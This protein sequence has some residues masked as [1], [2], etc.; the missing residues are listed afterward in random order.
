MKAGGLGLA[1]LGTAGL[2]TAQGMHHDNKKMADLFD[3]P[4]KNGEY[5]LPKLPYDYDA[6]EPVIDAQTTRLHHDIHF[7]GY[8][9][10][11]NGALKALKEARE[12]GD[13]SMVQ[14]HEG[15]LAFHG[16]GY[17][18]HL[19]FFA[20]LTAPGSSSPSSWMKNTLAEHFGSM[21]RFKAHFAAASKTVEGSGW[22]ILG[23]Q[24]IGDRLVVLQAEKHQNRTQWN[25]IPLLVIDVWEHAYYLNYQNR[26]GDYVDNFWKVVNW[27][28]VEKRMKLAMAL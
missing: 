18:L 25:V 20:H 26:R 27:D 11:L 13:F 16:A 24:P 19:V 10:G 8:K 17:F 22:G 12:S 3:A 9:N 21:E 28:V 5:S 4:M 23:Y 7:N 6:L 14:H 15:K 1:A 2:S